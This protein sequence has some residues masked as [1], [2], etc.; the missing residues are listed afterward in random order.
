MKQIRVT[1]KD[2]T[3]WANVDD[4]D[5]VF[6]SQ[7][8]WTASPRPTVTYARTNINTEVG[9]KCVEMHRMVIGD[10]EENWQLPNGYRPLR[11]ELPNGKT[12]YLVSLEYR[13]SRQM[14][15]DHKDGNGL[16]NTRENL[17]HL[18]SLDQVRNRF[19]QSVLT[20]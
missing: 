3:W 14:S 19:H 4:E 2:R 17:R 16:N 18:S 5:Y 11:H 12:I 15:V 7:Y 6:L 20:V 1:L 9:F 13:K 8:P 10:A